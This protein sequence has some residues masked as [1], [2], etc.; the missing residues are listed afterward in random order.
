MTGS[1]IFKF[2]NNIISKFIVSALLFTISSG[3][4]SPTF[5]QSSETVTYE[6]DKLN[7]VTKVTYV[8]SGVSLIY[9]YDAAGNRTSIQVQGSNPSPSV[10]SLS[11]NNANAGTTN[12]SIDVAGTNLVNGAVVQWNGSNRSTTYFGSFVRA[13]LNNA[14][15][16]TPGTA[17]VR[18]VNPAPSGGTTNELTFTVNQVQCLYSIS[19]NGV[20]VPATTSTGSFTVTAPEG[21][22]LTAV[23]NDN[24]L[25]ITSVTQGT[26]SYSVAANNG[27]PRIGTITV[28]GKIFT[29]TQ[30]SG[31]SCSVTALN[32]GQPVNGEFSNSDCTFFVKYHDVYTLRGI[33]GDQISISSNFPNVGLQLHSNSN[34]FVLPTSINGGTQFYTLPTSGAY[35]L[36]TDPNKRFNETGGTG[37][38]TIVLTKINTCINSFSPTTASLAATAST[39]NNFTVSAPT[40]CRW[41]AFANDNWI[42]VTS[43][44]PSSGN[45]LVSYSLT[46][47]SGALRTGSITV[48]GRNFIITQAGAP[49][50]ISGTVVYGTTM[51]NQTQKIVP[52]VLFSASGASTP[53]AN[54]DSAG[55][56]LL[57]NLIAGGQYTITPSKTG[58]I[59]G[60]SPFDATLI[61]RCVAAGS[62]SCTLTDNQK[63]AADTNGDNSISPFDATLI[64]RYVAAGAQNANTGQVGNW[65]FNPVSKNYPSLSS[66]SSNENY[67]GIL[68]GEVNGSWTPPGNSFNANPVTLGSIPDQSDPAAPCPIPGLPLDVQFPVSG[69]TGNVQSVSVTITFNPAHSWGGD[70]QATLISPDNTKNLDLF[71][72]TGLL[73]ASDY[74]DGSDLAGPYTFSDTATQS[75]WA[76]AS[77]GITTAIPSGSYRTSQRGGTGSTGANTS[78]N[79][80]FGG[81]IPAQANGIWT[82]R[83]TDGCNGDLGGVS[84]ASLNFTTN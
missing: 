53:S 51:A 78:L 72:S 34:G 44:M 76:A 22:P 14:D 15:L 13:R 63:I 33:E 24:W 61:L 81:L 67:E 10:T 79:A 49:Q 18:V 65:R 75:W 64:L 30:N 83:F 38:Y 77:V 17:T 3:M 80:V 39:G 62:M 7:R 36:F 19:S 58:N 28:G 9:T 32:Y 47:N 31:F 84:A 66:S 59:N 25:T 52:G 16:A 20:D 50:N 35:T 68:V 2:S 8:S 11:P 37:S 4:I 69:L 82:L 6:Y 48:D 73:A 54:S 12:L 70:V 26:V 42:T 71:G 60:I 55:A 46:P 23:T 41:T 27:T 56:Y 45:G 43:V 57:S 1:N 40:E 21:C 74:G 29:V 5:G